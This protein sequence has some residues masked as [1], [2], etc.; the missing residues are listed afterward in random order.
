MITEGEYGRHRIRQMDPRYI[1]V[2]TTQSY[3]RGA[4]ARTH[5]SI[6][7]RGGLTSSHNSLGYLTWHFSVDS[8]SVYQSL[9]TDEEG[10]HAD[11]EGTG[12]K[13][14]I[15]IE[16]CENRDGDFEATK[17]RTAKL[18]AHLMDQHSIPIS[19][20]VGHCHWERIRFDDGKNL[21]HKNCPKPLLNNGEYGPKW[22]AFLRQIESYR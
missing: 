16:M 19:R 20:V 13:H 6:L 11:Y 7:K 8:D 14:S 1:T 18:V 4:G 21:G 12:N 15:G 17:R 9:P 22:W 3:G 5:A 2:H 10:Q